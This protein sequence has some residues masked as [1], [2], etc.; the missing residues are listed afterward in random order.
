MGATIKEWWEYINRVR[1]SEVIEAEGG[2]TSSI[3][4]P[5]IKEGN[6]PSFCIFKTREE[7]E[8]FIKGYWPAIHL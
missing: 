7:C 5:N 3:F 6:L 8:R 1:N 2:Y 4:L